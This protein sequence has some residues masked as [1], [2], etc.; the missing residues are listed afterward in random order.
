M[1]EGYNLVK[2]VDETDEGVPKAS[3]SRLTAGVDLISPEMPN[4]IQVRVCGYS[5]A[6]VEIS[7]TCQRI[8]SWL[9]KRMSQR[10]FISGSR[11]FKRA[12]LKPEKYSWKLGKA[13]RSAFARGGL[14]GWTP[15]MTPL[16]HCLPW[17]P[18]LPW[19]PS[20]HSNYRSFVPV[21]T[22]PSWQLE[23]AM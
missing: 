4:A 7:Q 18:G 22:L 17:R 12:T 3:K 10:G 13:F 15:L 21:S 6:Q 20:S 11:A 8:L 2:D 1:H 23:I 5:C 14:R 16:S 19:L 9:S